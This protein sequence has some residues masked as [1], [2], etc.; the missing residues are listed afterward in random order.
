MQD[1]DP[2]VCVHLHWCSVATC[3]AFPNCHKAPQNSWELQGNLCAGFILELSCSLDA[4][5]P[6]GRA[7]PLPMPS[8]AGLFALG[9]LPFPA[10]AELFPFHFGHKPFLNPFKRGSTQTPEHQKPSEGQS[11]VLQALKTSLQPGGVLKLSSL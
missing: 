4:E 9:S 5:V 11:F 1:I 6:E 3:S 2:P 8:F 7:E 10:P